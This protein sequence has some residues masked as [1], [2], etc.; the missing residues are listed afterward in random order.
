MTHQ[1]NHL[2]AT[3]IIGILCLAL[4]LVGC[5]K[6]AG[7][8]PTPSTEG[9]SLTYTIADSVGD[10][11][12]PSPWGHY[13]RGPGYVRM[14]LIFDTLIWKNA[15]GL[16]PALA[17]EW[18]YEQSTKTYT[19][20]LR[21]D[22]YWHDSQKLT[23]QDVVFT[24]EYL[25][26]H[27]YPWV[28]LK[29]IKSVEAEGD[30]IKIILNTDLAPFLTN[31]AA[32]LPII[33]KHI[34]EEVREPEKYTEPSAAI[35]SGPFRYTDY[36]KEHGTYFFKANENYY[37]GQV[38]IQELKFVKVNPQMVAAALTKGE[39][40]AGSIQPEMVEQLQDKYTVLSESGSANVKLMFNHKKEPLARKEFRQAIAYALDREDLVAKSQRGHGLP[41]SP[42]LYVAGN[43]W[44][45]PDAQQ[46]AYNPRKTQELLTEL[47]YK[48]EA[49]QVGEENSFW[50]KN[51]QQ[52]KLELLCEASQ[53]RIAEVLKE[54]LA[55][56]G[57]NIEIKSVESKTRDARV[58]AWEFDLALNSHGGLASDPNL[59]NK[60][61]L[62]DDFNSARYTANEQ[63]VNLLKKQSQVMDENERKIIVQEIQKIY[64]EE[65]PA[66]TLY[67][68]NS[69]W[70]HNG[71]IPLFY[72]NEGIAIGVPI[73]LNKMSF[74]EIE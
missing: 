6:Q 49:A 46:Y 62:A 39:V 59:L 26:E 3:W 68:P 30:R 9:K 67:Y 5:T 72:T 52:I 56:V 23:V 55:K 12:F 63:L 8:S 73:P 50:L 54:Q 43:K 16:I 15:Q 7:Q 45:S 65:V 34:W 41:G 51:G 2:M 32:T 1:R 70:A 71:K 4:L 22:V 38:L 24:F 40:D 42:W 20:K 69:Y 37:G 60:F 29:N 28:D 58:L 36:D 31:V 17:S 27:P 18:D 64:A 66:F 44:H 74:V 19:F 57:L 47:G 25:K 53:I 35:G 10:W 21:D 14:S 13:Q 33:P 61:I 11:G 48:P